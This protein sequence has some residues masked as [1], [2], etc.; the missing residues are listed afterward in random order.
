MDRQEE[1]RLSKQQKTQKIQE[2]TQKFLALKEQKSK[3]D[4][5]AE[6]L[7]EKRDK[8]NTQFKKTRAE[9]TELK[10]ERDKLNAE[11][12]ELKQQREASKKEI[13]EKIEEIKRLK[14]EIKTL[15]PKKPPKSFQT[16]QKE[17]EDLEWKIQ[18]TSLEL[19]EEKEL[20]EKVKQL[21]TQLSVHKKLNQL[22]QQILK[23]QIEIKTLRDQGKLRHEKLMETAQRSQK[24]HEKMLEKIEES[25][26]IKIE[27]DNMHKLFLQSREKTNPLH[28]QMTE[29]SNQIK[30]LK[31]EIQETE[32]KEKK[33]TEEILREKLE[34]QA[35]E[36][37]RRGEKLTWEEF[38][39]LAKKGM[40]AQD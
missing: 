4:A 16:L 17:I 6:D 33:E 40:K 3:L 20:V 39:L 19:R 21:E 22:N 7:A 29:I 5:E 28:R 24:L 18:T 14:E 31:E 26:K 13:H 36:K 27:A 9:I 1:E 15:A 38:Q 25:K 12:K 32:T 8:L 2:L 11:V 37:L 35:R 10:G 23:L 34:S 30:R